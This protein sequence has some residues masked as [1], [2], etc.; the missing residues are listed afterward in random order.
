[1]TP[2]RVG[3]AGLGTVGATVAQLLLENAALFERRA[4]R[5]LDLTRVASRTPK[6]DVNLGPATFDTDLGSLDADDV[7]VVVELIGGVTSAK[8]VVATAIGAG[9][10]V[11]TANKALL[12]AH[13]EELFEAASR[14]GVSVGFEASVAGGIPIINALRT[15]LAANRI[16]ALAGIVNGT[17]NYILTAMEEE[18]QDFATALAEAQ[19]LGYAEADPTFDVEGID[20]AQKLAILA[21]LAF[22]ATIEFDGVHVEGISG[23]DI[24]DIRYA[25][26]LG[27][28]I[29][30][31]GIARLHE[32]GV[33]ARVHPA[34]VPDSV[35]IAKV[36]GVMNAVMTHGDAVGPTLYV[37][38]GAGGPPTASA[39]VAD[40]VELARGTLPVPRPAERRLPDLGIEGVI[41]AHYLK[42][43]AIDQPGVFAD[44]ADVLSRHDV[45]I[46]AVIQRPQAIRSGAEPWVPIIIVTDE[47]PEAVAREC[48]SEL[49]RLSGV[50]GEIARIRVADLTAMMPPAPPAG[51]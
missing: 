40:L 25:R 19:R 31:L 45:S 23:I 5:R 39:V 13:G 15:G 11:V 35:L 44:V 34:L 42:I 27:F 22:D 3:L 51:A 14:R 43:P 36:S 9:R 47:A 37:G 49:G 50:T 41:C 2:L 33:E 24:E 20:A 10:H 26:E 32:D 46:E 4:G 18:A 21:A 6:P 12:A 1:M 29:K 28:S 30:H 8:E 16:D 38:P 48:V 7:D 17:S